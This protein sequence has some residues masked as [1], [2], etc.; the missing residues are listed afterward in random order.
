MSNQLKKQRASAYTGKIPGTEIARKRAELQQLVNRNLPY[1]SAMTRQ[2]IRALA[3]NE[4]K[5]KDQ[6]A[7]AELRK[8][9]LGASHA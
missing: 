8:C 7:R 3:R 1:P 9:K 6:K 2:M 4:A 5:L